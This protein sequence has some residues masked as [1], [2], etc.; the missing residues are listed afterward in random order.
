MKARAA[1]TTST[2]STDEAFQSKESSQ[3]E[4]DQRTGRAIQ[5]PPR[6]TS[7]RPLRSELHDSDEYVLLA[8]SLIQSTLLLIT[9]FYH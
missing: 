5:A 4:L 9:F 1:E 6:P 8:H 2:M 7:N 3:E